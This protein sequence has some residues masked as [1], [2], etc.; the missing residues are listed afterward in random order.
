LIVVLH[1]L[2]SLH[3]EHGDVTVPGLRREEW[4]GASYSDDE[5][6]ELAEILPDVPFFGT[7]SL[8]ERIWSGPAATVTGI[9]VLSVDRAVNAVVPYARAKV[10]L[11][12]HP[13]Q[14]P[15][16]A[17][18]AL[19]RYLEGLRPFGVTLTVHA[20]ETGS[21]FAARTGGPAYEAAREALARAWGGETV[22]IATGGSIPLVSALQEAAP[23]AEM[24][25]PGTTDGFANI[26]A[27]NERV[28]IDEFEKAIVAEAEF[29]GLYAEGAS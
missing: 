13:E 7:G 25:P 2:A 21:G 8:A 10:S 16:E 28:L 23:E 14:D 29:F 27:P 26:H 4:D 15:L 18:A 20:A 19:V 22:S 3:D 24:P 5:F 11:R 6:R 9:D 12:V 1:A 17:Q